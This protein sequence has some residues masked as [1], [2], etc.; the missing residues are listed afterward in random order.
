MP[1]FRANDPDV[2]LIGGR[3]T[4]TSPSAKARYVYSYTWEIENLFEEG[5]G[6][7]AL[8]HLKEMTLPSFVV[9]K[10]VYT[11]ASV[12]YKYAKSIN[13]EDIKV[14]WY[15]TLRLVLAISEWRKRVWTPEGG[16]ARSNDYK[17]RSTIKTLDPYSDSGDA[18]VWTLYNSWPSTIRYG[19]LTYTNSDIKIVEVSITYDWALEDRP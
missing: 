6:E 1:G 9:T 17:K 13:W 14:T 18:A 8:I 5:L 7:G 12:D 10:E 15:D 16:L 3:G 2:G 4:G 11:A 19:D